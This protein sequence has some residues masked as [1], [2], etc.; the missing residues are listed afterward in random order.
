MG[1][2][3]MSRGCT[4]VHFVELDPWVVKACLRRN[5][6][7]CGLDGPHSLVH[8]CRVEEFLKRAALSAAPSAIA[9]FDFVSVTPPYLDV[10]FSDVFDLLVASRLLHRRSVVA[11][12]YSK[13]NVGDIRSNIGHLA[14]VKNRSYGRTKLA[15]YAS[16]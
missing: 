5:I 1:L 9:P 16:E 15:V 14:L 13:Q 12:E 6:A 4:D 10:A 7:A 2:E 3:A 11:V 8:Q